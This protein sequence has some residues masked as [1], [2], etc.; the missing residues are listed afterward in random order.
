MDL[1]CPILATKAIFPPLC[2]F[3]YTHSILI[4]FFD[5][6]FLSVLD[7]DKRNERAKKPA[8]DTSYMRKLTMKSFQF[9]LLSCPRQLAF[10]GSVSRVLRCRPPPIWHINYQNRNFTVKKHAVLFFS[11]VRFRICV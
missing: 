8:A 11:L 4:F 1:P 9:D 2:L 6:I 10:I 3:G 5:N 7:V